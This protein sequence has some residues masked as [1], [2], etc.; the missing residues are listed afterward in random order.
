MS[1]YIEPVD[2]STLKKIGI[3]VAALVAITLCLI[4]V[5]AVLT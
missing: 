5:A 4:V 3:N 2:A 1:Q